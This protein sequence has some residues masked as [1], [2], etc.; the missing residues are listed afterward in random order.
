MSIKGVSMSIKE[1]FLG[2]AWRSEERCV[3]MWEVYG[4][5][6]MDLKDQLR[7]EIRNEWLL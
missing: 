2:E 5:A 6:A 7:N 3:E 4:Q 1:Q